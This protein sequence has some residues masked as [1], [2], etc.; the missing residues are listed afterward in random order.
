[1]VVPL[2]SIGPDWSAV[3]EAPG[4]VMEPDVLEVVGVSRVGKR[5]S[6]RRTLEI[7]PVCV[8]LV[9]SWKSEENMEAIGYTS[10]IATPQMMERRKYERTTKRQYSNE[11]INHCPNTVELDQWNAYQAA[12]GVR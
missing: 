12:R 11:V 7:V 5:A 10:F 1:M 8:L 2:G 6:F 3:E 4:D 9:I